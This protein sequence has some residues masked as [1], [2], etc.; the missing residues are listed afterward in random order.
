MIFAYNDYCKNIVSQCQRKIAKNNN[1]LCLN[2]IAKY[3]KILL[4]ILFLSL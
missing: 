4:D 2:F 3:L 1:I